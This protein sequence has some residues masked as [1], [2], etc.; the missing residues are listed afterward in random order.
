MADLN[1]CYIRPLTLKGTGRDYVYKNI[2][3]TDYC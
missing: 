3:S 1:Y 2:V